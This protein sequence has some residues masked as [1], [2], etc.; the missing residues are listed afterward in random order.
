MLAIISVM[1]TTFDIT[2][3]L[4]HTN[5]NKCSLVSRFN[6]TDLIIL[7]LTVY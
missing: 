3:A 6:L 7:S 2:I 5:L 4:P 1:I